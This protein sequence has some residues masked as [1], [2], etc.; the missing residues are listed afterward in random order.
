M[1]GND[2]W[3]HA[4]DWPGAYVFVKTL[5]GK[6]VP[7]ETMLDAGNLAVFYSKGRSSGGGDIYYTQV[8]FLRR[9]RDGK[10]GLV[11]PTREK[12]LYI[13]LDPERVARLRKSQGSME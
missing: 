11:I 12:N 7:L 6:S 2:Y 8:K 3:F 9:A 13:R 5:K 1:A 10:T 4:R